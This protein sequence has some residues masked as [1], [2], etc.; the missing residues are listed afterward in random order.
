MAKRQMP[1]EKLR[2]KILRFV[3]GKPGE[4]S[5]HNA[6]LEYAKIVITTDLIS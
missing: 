6:D 4:D 1:D 2:K 3:A 5:I